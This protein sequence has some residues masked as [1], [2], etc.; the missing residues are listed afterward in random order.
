MNPAIP[1]SLGARVLQAPSMFAPGCCSRIFAQMRST[2]LAVALC[3]VLLA[4]ALLR[5]AHAGQVQERDALI[6]SEGARL[7]AVIYVPESTPPLPALISITASIRSLLSSAPAS[8]KN[9]S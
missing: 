6:V 7:H 8:Q 3:A 1:I 4:G 9:T 2:Q 5:C